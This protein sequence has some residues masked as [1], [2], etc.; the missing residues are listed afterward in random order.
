[1]IAGVDGCHGS[2]I[3]ALAGGW[4]CR[5]PPVFLRCS[6]FK[7]MLDATA[8]CVAV[9]ADM[10]IGLPTGAEH[11]RCDEIGRAMLGPGGASRLFY[12]PP[13]PSLGA[14]T[15][16]EFQQTH[17][18]IVGKGAGLPVW[19]IVPRLAEVDAAMGPELQERVYEF[20]PELAWQHL[21]GR[22]LASKHSREGLIRRQTLLRDYIPGLDEL[23]A[24]RD[25]LRRRD[26]SLDDLL[27]A[28]VGLR[29]AGAIA[30]GPDHARRIPAGEPERDGRGLRMEIWF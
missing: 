8:G 1:M 5:Q 20:H 12:A 17:R 3:V 13:R 29:V 18:A 16:T 6:A 22:P 19:G 9:V 25:G 27:D 23:T 28:L 2:W 15:A 24:A 26:A 30:D 4:P 14:R 21:D 11:R 7:E 10:P